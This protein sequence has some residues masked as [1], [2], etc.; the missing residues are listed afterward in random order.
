MQ[1]GENLPPQSHRLLEVTAVVEDRIRK[2]K[3]EA[4]QEDILTTRRA[5]INDN[6]LV[7]A[8]ARLRGF[9]DGM[10]LA[11]NLLRDKPDLSAKEDVGRI[12]DAPQRL[13]LPDRND[14]NTQAGNDRYFGK[15]LAPVNTPETRDQSQACS[16]AQNDRSEWCEQAKSHGGELHAKVTAGSEQNGGEQAGALDGVSKTDSRLAQ[17]SPQCGARPGEQDKKDCEAAGAQ[18]LSA[19]QWL[20]SILPEATNGWWDVRDKGNGTTVKFRWRDSGL[21]VITL[22][23]IT[24]EQF[25]ILKQSDYED[26]K[27]VIREKISLRLHSLSLDPAKR[28]KALIAAWK[29]GIDLD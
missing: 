28:D 21:Q 22:L 3:A 5:A 27:S 26:A 25:E 24:S 7:L 14:G 18:F 13:C 16:P 9:L 8:A 11:A 2:L 23:R 29:L 19:S 1:Q 15:T 10:S 4:V 17:S 6:P 20:K 12:L